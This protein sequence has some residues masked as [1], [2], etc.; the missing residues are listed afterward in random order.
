MRSAATLSLTLLCLGVVSGC[1]ALVDGT[2][3]GRNGDAGTPGIDTGPIPDT[4]PMPDTGPAS[5]CAGLPDGTQC[6]VPGILEPFV[7]L[8]NICQLSRCGD[9]IHD[10][11]MQASHVAEQCDDGNTVSGDGCENDC[12]FSCEASSD[13]D[14]TLFCNGSETCDTTMHVCQAG[15][16]NTE[17]QACTVAGMSA[18]CHGGV[19][20]AGM[21][22]DH[23]TDAG[24]ECDDGNPN[25]GD[26]CDTDCTF[27]C[28]DDSECQD[29]DSCNGNESCNLTTHTCAA[30][31]EPLACDDS[32]PCT[33]DTCVAATGCVFTSVL[34]DH[35]GDGSFAP[36]ASCGGDDC[37]D[38]DPTRHPGANEVCP[39]TVDSNCDGVVGMA[40][41]WYRDCDGDGYAAAGA[42][43]TSSCTQPTGT[44]SCASW[45]QRAPGSGTTDCLDTSAGATTR[46]NQTSYFTTSVSGQSPLFDYNCSASATRQY[47]Y[48]ASGLVP[49]GSTSTC[50]YDTRNACRGDA[51]Y[52]SSTAPACGASVSE[53]H[54]AVRLQCSGLICDTVCTRIVETERVGCH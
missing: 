8:D 38:N 4:G 45:T 24:E 27:S 19:C 52:V 48:A 23:T 18:V 6:T 16:E 37:D 7:C 32:D 1:T 3:S 47:S 50:A 5:P 44:A 43:T 30:A 34:V 49:R 25:N 22:G 9:G 2:L 40:S 14:D 28:H 15:T 54:C 26:G 41:T 53:S 39:G 21:C 17:G 13:C 36:T 29:G 20:R 11:R 42:S 46:P 31:V 12:S 35:D 10:D 33:T 51:W